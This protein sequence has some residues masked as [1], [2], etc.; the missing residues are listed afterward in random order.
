[1]KMVR[2]RT[3]F[4]Y[5]LMDK[6]YQSPAIEAYAAL[7]GRRV[8]VDRRS[9]RSGPPVPLDA[10]DALRYM[11]RTTVERTN[12]E[13]KDGFL[14]AKMYRR[15]SQARYDIE[16]AIL[17]TTLKMAGRVLRMKQDAATQKAA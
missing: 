8:I 10:A 16:L 7:I 15:G 9:T 2:R 14:P 4:F 1:M 17:L 6:G 3:D 5:A 11:A 13:L 12:S